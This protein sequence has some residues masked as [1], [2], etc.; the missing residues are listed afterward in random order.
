MSE[1]ERETKRFKETV[2]SGN[3]NE[4]VSLLMSLPPDVRVNM[5][6]YLSSTDIFRLARINKDFDQ[7]SKTSRDLWVM[8]YRRNFG[9]E[10]SLVQLKQVLYTLFPNI[11]EGFFAQDNYRALVLAYAIVN[12]IDEVK[13]LMNLATGQILVFNRN[14]VAMQDVKQPYSGIDQQIDSNVVEIIKTIMDEKAVRVNRQGEISG[15]FD[16]QKTQITLGITQIMI[17]VQFIRLGYIPKF[18]YSDRHNY[19]RTYPDRIIIKSQCVACSKPAKYRSNETG[20]LF[21]SQECTE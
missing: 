21:C 4:T 7:W 11:G 15:T 1:A 13:Y 20:E 17:M 8:L 6:G 9:D 16:K 10:M 5:A 14:I 18:H 12:K 2:E 3:D 19:T